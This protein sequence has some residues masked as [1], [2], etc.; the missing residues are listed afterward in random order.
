[1]SISKGNKFPT[2][3]PVGHIHIMNDDRVF[4]YAGGDILNMSRWLQ[5]PNNIEVTGIL[6]NI[7]ERLTKAEDQIN[8]IKNFKNESM[9]KR[10]MKKVKK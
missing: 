3:A 5:I 4:I 1:M 9:L 6:T 10:I 2:G 8:E 7:Q